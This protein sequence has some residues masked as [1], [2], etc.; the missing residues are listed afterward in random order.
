MTDDGT[1]TINTGIKDATQTQVIEYWNGRNTLDRWTN[2]S[3]G[4]T[5]KCNMIVGTDG[6]GYPPFRE[7][8]QKMTIFSSDICRFVGWNNLIIFLHMLH[9]NFDPRTVDI[10][11]VGPSSYEGIPALRFETDKNFLNE[12]GPEYG[13]DCYCVNRIPKAIVKDNGCLYKGALDLSTCFGKI[14]T[15]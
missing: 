14:L 11:Y 1:Y 13:N 15:L 12:I 10:K 3:L 8:V 9:F 5:S 7:G 6:S 2:R 4:S